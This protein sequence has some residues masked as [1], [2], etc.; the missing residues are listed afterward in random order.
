M[1]SWMFLM[2]LSAGSSLSTF[3]I[4]LYYQDRGEK[5]REAVSRKGLSKPVGFGRWYAIHVASRLG[6]IAYELLSRSAALL[7]FWGPLILIDSAMFAAVIPYAWPSM[8]LFFLLTMGVGRRQTSGPC[9]DED[10][11]ESNGCWD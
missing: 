4:A 1:Q 5:A 6:R 11:S 7:L 9:D 2:L 3:L 8:V 10:Q